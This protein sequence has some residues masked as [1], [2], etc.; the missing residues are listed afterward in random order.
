MRPRRLAAFALTAGLWLQAGPALAQYCD[1][2]DG[3]D[4]KVSGRIDRMVEAAGVIFFRDS[5]T[6]CQFGMAL[7]RDDK[8]C[9]IGSQVDV[10]GKLI[11][12]KFMPDTYDVD[13]GGKPAAQT[14]TCK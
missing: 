8:G 2:L 6:S 9:K 13:R 7:Q 1:N 5:R 10:S 4:V 3:Q 11:R 14:L 12:N